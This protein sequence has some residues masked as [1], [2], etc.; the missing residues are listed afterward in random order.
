MP[1]RFATAALAVLTLALSGCFQLHTLLRLNADGSGTIEETV[2]LQGFLAA[3]MQEADS[4][5]TG[6]IDLAHFQARADSLGEGVRFLRVDSL[7]EGGSI[8]YRAVYAFDDINTVRYVS[9]EDALGTGAQ[10][11][12]AGPKGIDTPLR[13]A[14]EPGALTILRERERAAA[15]ARPLDSTEVAL[16]ADSI[17]VQMEQGGAMARAFLEG[18][19]L[20]I[21][22][23]L[24]GPITETNARYA[25]DG[26]VT[27]A[28]VD[29]ASIID[30]MIED[31]EAA[32]RMQ[33]AETD[34]DRQAAFERLG[35]QPG[36]RVEPEDEVTVRFEE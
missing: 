27:L 12:E 24:P 7:E 33:L 10:N 16:K 23:E 9:D 5:G 6:L 1:H 20:A 13:F 11:D 3:M 35:A 18:A 14:Y 26:T 22:V 34:A 36:F 19:R 29:M 32:A 8:G 30:L 17:R 31:P 25:E 21:T 2:L 4:T 28:D 15:D